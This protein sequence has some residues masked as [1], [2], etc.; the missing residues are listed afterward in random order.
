MDERQ[1]RQL[2]DAMVRLASGDREA[3]TLVFEGLWPPL[4]AFM[5][6][7][8]PGHPDREDLAQRTLLNMFARISEFDVNRDG[9]AW[10]FG[11]A[12]YEVKTLRRQMQRRREK[13]VADFGSNDRADDGGGSP[14]EAAIRRD[15][16]AAL[17]EALG[18]LTPAERDVLTGEEDEREKTGVSI[19]AWR[20]RRQRALD[21]LRA[22]WGKRHA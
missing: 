11:I 16:H 17:T 6:R 22:I 4:L 19:T 8:L 20:K 10:V 1:R 13:S 3:F 5:N 18:E 21:K 14:E 9:V 15:L 7:A 2:H 12:S